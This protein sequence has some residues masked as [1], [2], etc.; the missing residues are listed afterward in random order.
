MLTWP[1][2]KVRWTGSIQ[3]AG[4]I[5]ISDQTEQPLTV[6]PGTAAR[7]DSHTR[8]SRAAQFTRLQT[9]W[10]AVIGSSLSGA[11]TRA[12]KGG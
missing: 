10:A 11:N 6:Q 12:A 7:T 4:V 3:K 2:A 8:A 1:K 5:S 9:T